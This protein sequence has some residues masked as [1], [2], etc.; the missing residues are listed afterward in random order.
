MNTRILPLALLLACSGSEPGPVEPPS[1][2]T[3]KTDAG[4]EETPETEPPAEEPAADPC[5]QDA[6]YP[7]KG[8]HNPCTCGPDDCV[9]TRKPGEPADPEYPPTWTSNWTMYRVFNNYQDNLPPWDSPPA[10]LEEGEDYEV[11]YG[12]TAY[13]ST[14]TATDGTTGAMMEHYD[15]RCLP[16][17]PIDNQF[18]CSFVSLGDTAY[19]LTYEQD[20]PADMPACCLFSPYNHPPRTDF[21][22]RLPYNAED[23]SHVDDQL[24]A[25]RYIAPNPA[26]GSTD[27]DQGIWFAYAFWKDRFVDADKKYKLPQSFYFSGD[28][29]TPPDAP[30]VSQNYSDFT[31]APP[32][33]TKTWD[34]VAAMCPARDELPACQLFTPPTTKTEAAKTGSQWTTLDHSK[35]GAK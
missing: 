13:D 4:G 2:D 20:R 3:P 25:Y 8:T 34:Q 18:T 19:F 17:F 27:P 29:G 7:S 33:P 16:I 22:K 1:E 9:E 35:E 11:S 30:F 26:T 15:K 14:Y 31:N 24:Q 12:W 21:I 23:S 10:G 6:V 28:P 32:D 5:K